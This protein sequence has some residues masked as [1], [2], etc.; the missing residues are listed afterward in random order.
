MSNAKFN[1]YSVVMSL[2]WRAIW[3]APRKTMHP[4]PFIHQNHLRHL[5]TWATPGGFRKRFPG[6]PPYL[7]VNLQPFCFVGGDCKGRVKCI[8]ASSRSIHIQP[9]DWLR[10]WLARATKRVAGWS[11]ASRQKKKPSQQEKEEVKEEEIYT[12]SW[13]LDA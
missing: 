11:K 8:E 6:S 7:L 12:M 1:N 3:C 2:P 5:S 4:Q 10:G 9:L 13:L